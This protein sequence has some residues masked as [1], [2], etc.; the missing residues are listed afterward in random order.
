MEIEQCIEEDL[1]DMENIINDLEYLD[2]QDRKLAIEDVLIY[3]DKLKSSIHFWNIKYI[4]D[5][6]KINS[7]STKLDNTQ[8]PMNHFTSTTSPKDLEKTKE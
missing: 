2:D 1:K 6:S 8:T 4:E 3:L 5:P 7:K